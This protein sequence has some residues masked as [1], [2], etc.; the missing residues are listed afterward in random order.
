MSRSSSSRSS[1]KAS[2]AANSE[3]EAR[4]KEIRLFQAS[5]AANKACFDC[6]QR[7]PTYVN[8]TTGTFVCT[9]V[10]GMLRGITPPHRIKSLSMSSFSAEEVAFIKARGNSWAAKVYTGLYEGDVAREMRDD[11]AVR[12]FIVEKYERKRYYVDPS[13]IV[14]SASATAGTASAT[15]GHQRGR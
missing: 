13:Q 5:D 11:E 6:G 1:S 10:A 7:G 2:S 15:N 9:K 14:H 4:T 8:M 3:S 12:A